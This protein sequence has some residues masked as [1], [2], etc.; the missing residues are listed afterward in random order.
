M[1]GETLGH[2]TIL[3]KIGAGGMGVVYRARDQRLERDV[4]V[5]VLPVGALADESARKRF[6]KE[7]LALSQLNH[8]NI[9]TIYDFNTQDG[10][11]YLVMEFIPGQ[12]LNEKLAAGS[13]VER[14][15]IRL[16]SQ[17]AQGLTAAHEVGMV[18]RDLKP[19]NLRVTPDGRLK[20]LDFGLA[21]LHRPDQDASTQSA[22]DDRRLSGTIPY[23][24]PEQLRG[25][26]IDSR[27]DIYA[28]GAVLY[29]MATGRRP[30]PETHGAQLIAAILQQTPPTPSSVDRRVSPGLETITLKALDKDPE[31]RYQAAKELLVDLER[32]SI[33]APLSASASRR[34]RPRRWAAPLAASLAV[35]L[36]AVLAGLDVGR[37]RSSVWERVSGRRAGIESVAVLPLGNL[38]GDASQ[39]AFADGMTEALTAELAQLGS[40]RVASR[41][42]VMQYKGVKKPLPEIGRELKVDAVVEGSIAR[43]GDQ[44][45]ITAQLIDART[46]RHLW[47]SNFERKLDNALSVQAGVAK[48]IA[49][50]IQTKVLTLVAASAPTQAGPQ[51]LDLES[52]ELGQVPSGWFVP[53]TVAKAGYTAK[54]VE[55]NPNSGKRCAVILRE[56]VSG[57]AP[58]GNLM[59]SFDAAPYRGKRVR[60]RAAVRTETGR[61]PDQ[62]QLWLRVDRKGGQMAFL[63]NMENRPIRSPEWRHYEIQ[64]EVGP[65]AEK[66]NIGLML[67]GAGKEWLD[68]VSFEIIGQVGEGN[69]PPRPLRGRALDNLVAFTRLLG[70]LRYFHPSDEAARLNWDEFA[71]LGVQSVEPARN[72]AQ[73]AQVLE[74]LFRPYAPALQVFRAGQAPAPVSLWPPKE[75]QPPRT[76]A[77]VHVGVAGLGPAYIYSSHRGTPGERGFGN[78]MRGVEAVPYRGK[79]VRFR[80][81]VR[82][83][84]PGSQAQLW[85]RVDRPSGQR[86]FF[87]NMQDRPIT[88]NQWRSYE[89]AGQVAEDAERVYFGCMLIGQGRAWVDAASFEIVDKGAVAGPAP[90]ANMDFEQGDLDQ[91]PTGWASGQKRWGGVRYQVQVSEESPRQGRRCAAL[92]SETAALSLPDPGS[93]FTAELGAGVT[94]RFPL[95]LYS[96][97]EGTLPRAAPLVSVPV[98]S[99]PRGF[100]PS[101]NDRATRLAAVA[102]LWNVYQHFSP[103]LDEAR[104]DWHG[105]LRR[106][107]SAAA[108]DSGPEQFLETLRR[109][110]AEPRDGFGQVSHAGVADYYTP[111]LL[112][113]WIQDNLVITQVG[114]DAAGLKPGDV[115][116]K[117]NGRPVRAALADAEARSAQPSPQGRRWQALQL[118]LFG[119]KDSPL[120][121]E[122][123]SEWRKASTITLRRA[124]RTGELREARPANLSFLRP[125][126]FYVDL[127]RTSDAD[128]DGALGKLQEARQIILDLR[129][130]SRLSFAR[131]GHFIDGEVRSAQWLVPV[132][133]YPDRQRISWDSN[134]W[135]VIP[136]APRLKGRVAVL[137]GAGSAETE[138]S[139]IAHYKLAEIVGAA[140]SGSNGNGN[141]VILPGGYRVYFRGMKAQRHDGGPYYGVGIQPT[142]AAA[143]TIRGVAEGRDEALE[144]AM[145]V[146]Y[147]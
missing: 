25:D 96:D 97:S 10:V 85:M 71:I 73:L 113:D 28:A 83:Q 65:D 3:E 60:L 89:I 102:L 26:K 146:S 29:E 63:D 88:S 129:S 124:L 40:L 20:I 120:A 76:T 144:R 119:L 105:A 59:Q 145:E 123:Q 95:A 128:F 112:W 66:I 136:L 100:V 44:V 137:A 107:L 106:A 117:V 6:R 54:L 57:E 108:N 48:A 138:L 80:A 38:T 93:P 46:D 104:A 16:G 8:P 13:L 36:L 42:S 27:V 9:A 114:A 4:A 130:F 111:P 58:F 68:S 55:E 62:G 74:S 99:K 53:A 82:T 75:V 135:P 56:S 61:M 103:Y 77:W 126:V 43:S 101:G 139:I 21:L 110:A 33:S 141:T 23:M 2:Y 109:L 24:A 125:G 15:I 140:T 118:L 90:L 50:D 122:V 94:C 127:G 31:R 52:G 1:I 49:Q 12:T 132:S 67:K 147:R 14:E 78:L 7:A 134:T 133:L 92:S 91:A 32:L 81:A 79:K 87:D 17:L 131:W 45:R 121:L 72:A 47:A 86:G 51:N 41:T 11:D 84:G 30:F 37:W 34:A 116:L 69:H 22:L 18:H 143:R 115:V 64:G 70:Y 39:D 19:G 142:V 5:K 35:V 98:S